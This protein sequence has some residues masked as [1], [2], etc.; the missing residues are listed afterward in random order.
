MC[1]TV[2][3]TLWTQE[4]GLGPGRAGGKEDGRLGRSWQGG[5]WSEKQAA[6]N[7]T[8]PGVQEEG[9]Q[10]RPGSLPQASH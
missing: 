6:L 5:K 4:E 8:L 2:G 1:A 10:Q 7:D 3:G 9:S